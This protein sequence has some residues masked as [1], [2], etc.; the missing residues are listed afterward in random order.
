MSYAGSIPVAVE[1]GVEPIVKINH[2]NHTSNQYVCADGFTYANECSL[3]H[4]M[5]TMHKISKFLRQKV[6][7]SNVMILGI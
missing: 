1:G 2:C 4:R 6:C 3:C 7:T 5:A